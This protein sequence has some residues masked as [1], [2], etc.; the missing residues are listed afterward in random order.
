M[1]DLGMISHVASALL[2]ISVRVSTLMLLAPFLG[3]P[4][5]PVRIK[6]GATIA[7]TALLAAQQGFRPLPV[8]GW[9]VVTVV[10]G[11]VLAGLCLAFSLQLVFD[12]AQFAA[13][14]VGLQ[15]GFSYASIVDPQTQAETTAISV[16]CQ[17]IVLLIFLRLDVHHWLLRG[18]AK[19]FEYVPPG[20]VNFQESLVTHLQQ[21]I[22][23][24][25]LA[26]LQIAAP[27][28]IATVLADFALAL[29]G[30]A[31]PQLPVLFVGM[32][33]KAMLGMFVMGTALLTWPSLFHAQFERAAHSAER[34]LSLTR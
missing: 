19:S 7:I 1:N 21:Q 5:I 8:D 2:Y 15:M 17:T 30:K 32:S 33:V 4:G 13:H 18:L 24:M 16:F 23:G 12:A 22:N 28:L 29:I 26:G 3:S 34:M 11:E 31:S 9:Q 6:A 27:I 25:F 14:I 10:A 20:S